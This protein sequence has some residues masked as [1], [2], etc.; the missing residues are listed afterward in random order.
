MSNL[1]NIQLHTA[2]YQIKNYVFRFS[3]YTVDVVTVI[4]ESV[5]QA[6]DKNS[7]ARVVTLD[8]TKA[9]DRVFGMLAFPTSSMTIVSLDKY[10]A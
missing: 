7:E 8:I 6:L 3:R 4:T 1:L 5:Y 10:L 9:F 2:S